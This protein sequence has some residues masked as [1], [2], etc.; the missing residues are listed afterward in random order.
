[1]QV[2]RLGDAWLVTLTGEVF[3]EIGWQV[4]DAVAQAAGVPP[5]RVVVAA[6]ANAGIGYVPTADAIT[7]GGYE[8]VAYRYSDRP[9]GYVPHAGDLL[10][11][12]AGELAAGL[13]DR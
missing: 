2:L 11:A 12:A 8:P 13:A 9:A 1:V 4:R 6:Y 5:D 10:A 3:V 7:Q